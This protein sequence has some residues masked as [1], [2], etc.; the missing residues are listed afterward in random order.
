[1]LR[2]YSSSVVLLQRQAKALPIAASLIRLQVASSGLVLMTVSLLGRG[3][4]SVSIVSIV[5]PMASP[6]VCFGTQVWRLPTFPSAPRAVDEVRGFKLVLIAGL[7]VFLALRSRIF[8][9]ED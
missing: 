9:H 4:G 3:F 1:M 2:K 6:W 7:C 8:R 5:L